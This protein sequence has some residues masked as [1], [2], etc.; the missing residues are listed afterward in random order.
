[1]RI[2][3]RSALWPDPLSCSTE[4]GARLYK[5]GDLVKYL[6]D[7]NLEYLGRLDHQV[8]I[9]GF[10][11]ELGEIESALLAVAGVR[12]AVVLARE[13]IPGDRR[14]V[15]Y[16]VCEPG[17]EPE[18]R[19]LQSYLKKTLPEYMVPSA[20]VVLDSLPLTPNGK[21]DRKALPSPDAGGV[22]AD[23]Y[24]APRTPIE[25]GLAEIWG[26]VLH[27]ERVG[28]EDSFFDLGGHSLLATQVVSRMRNTFQVELPLHVLF[29]APT[30]AGLAVEIEQFLTLKQQQENETLA[31]LLAEIEQLSVQEAVVQLNTPEGPGNG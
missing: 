1:M 29:D 24:I 18:L 31:Q 26:A 7:G 2:R 5:T 14:L 6:K 22:Q 8:K 4:P 30:V 11:I 17:S 21:G 15:A 20:L 13:D 12:E 16:I 3:R 19:T 9:R 25:E 28:I 10:R 23:T 27:V